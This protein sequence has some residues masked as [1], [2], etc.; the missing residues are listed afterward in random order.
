MRRYYQPLPQ[1]FRIQWN[2]RKNK[3]TALYLNSVILITVWGMCKKND[4]SVNVIIKTIRKGLNLY[5][6]GIF[7]HQQ[8]F[9]KW[10]VLEEFNVCSLLSSLCIVTIIC[11][12]GSKPF[13]N[14]MLASGQLNSY[15]HLT[16]AFES[17]YTIFMN[18]HLKCKVLQIQFNISTIVT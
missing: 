17:R 4:K 9:V 12:L 1:I 5:Q 13:S 14:T 8:M 6:Y 2:L 16:M 7:P 18:I 10:S 11:L 15:V 3:Y